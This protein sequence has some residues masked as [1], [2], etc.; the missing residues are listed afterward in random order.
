MRISLCPKALKAV[1]TTVLL[2]HILNLVLFFHVNDTT[3]MLRHPALTD[4]GGGRII[5]NLVVSSDTT[6][7]KINI[8]GGLSRFWL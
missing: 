5:L 8:L 4:R 3:S 7:T 6:N 1:Y 2:V